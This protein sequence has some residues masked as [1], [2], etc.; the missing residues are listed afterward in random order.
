[1]AMAGLLGPLLREP[2]DAQRIDL[3][4]RGTPVSAFVGFVEAFIISSLFWNA[5]PQLPIA[6]WLAAFLAVRLGRVALAQAYQRAQ[7]V[8]PADL[9]RWSRWL[10]VSA[11]VQS[12]AWG[13][14]KKVD[15]VQRADDQILL[16]WATKKD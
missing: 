8:A 11:G 7:P 9:P 3:L 6:L 16:Y 4:Y 13:L 15:I 2:V 14:S 1:M 10:L 5:A 12:L